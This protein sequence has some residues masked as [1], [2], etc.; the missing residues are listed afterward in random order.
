M[1]RRSACLFGF[2][3]A[4]CSSSSRHSAACRCRSL[5]RSSAASGTPSTCRRPRRRSS[6]T[7]RSSSARSRGR[8]DAV[9][10]HDGEDR[11]VGRRPLDQHVASAPGA[12]PVL[13]WSQM[14]GDEPT[15]TAA[16]FDIFEYLRRHRDDPA[17]RARILS[18]AEALVHSDAESRRR[19][20]V[21]APERAGHRHQPRRAPAADAR[22]A[23]AQGRAGSAI[24]RAWASTCTTRAGGR[25]SAIRRSR[26]RSRSC[27]W[28][29][30]RRVGEAAAR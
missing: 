25:R 28:P 10:L 3:A 13:L 21:P 23:H 9:A 7:P 5:R 20:A 22:R 24:S 8:G 26:R 16:L 11:R 17:V 30:T 29:S 12:F 4:F 14:H 18:V 15:A 6:I 1:S 27:R 2:A 19:R